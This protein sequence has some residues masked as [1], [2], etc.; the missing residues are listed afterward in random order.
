V[1]QE[2][3]FEVFLSYHWQDRTTVEVIARSLQQRGMRPFLDRWYLSP[4]QV[5]AL[6]NIL[7]GCGAVLVFVGSQGVGR[8]QQREVQLALDRQ[9]REPSLPVI[10]V[11]LTGADPALGFLSLNTWVDLRGGTTEE[12]LAVLTAAICSEPPGPD[13]AERIRATRAAI[14]PYRGLRLFREEDA[15]FFCGREAFTDSLEQ[16]VSR[17][18]MVGVVGASGSGKSSVARAG[19][20]PR[21]RRQ[22]LGNQCGTSSPWCRATVHCTA[23]PPR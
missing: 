18:S 17:R 12:A 20:L 14:C 10:P 8:W 1:V 16:V 13:V 22:A 2:Q 4:G 9:T 19:L 6:Q 7:G 3:A 11:L 15:A 21:L 5:T 23:S